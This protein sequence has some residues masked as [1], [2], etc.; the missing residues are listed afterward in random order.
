[1][2][3]SAGQV[4]TSPI[5]S[6][7]EELRGGDDK[8]SGGLFAS[9]SPRARADRLRAAASAVRREKEFIQ[10]NDFKVTTFDWR[11]NDLSGGRVDAAA[12]PAAGAGT[13][14]AS[15]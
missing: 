4:S 14:V 12:L 2:D 9:R 11:L 3:R 15:R 8:N 10:K 1:M 7:H 6:W 5:L 13:P